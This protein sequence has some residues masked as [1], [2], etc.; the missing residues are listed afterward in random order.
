LG[1]QQQQQQQ[2]AFSE[3]LNF[4]ICETEINDI[5][6]KQIKVLWSY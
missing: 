6:Q 3:F 4:E 5:E 2:K 1:K